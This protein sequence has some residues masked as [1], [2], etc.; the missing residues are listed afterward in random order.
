MLVKNIIFDLGGVLVDW[1]PKYVYRQVF[2]T[3]EA[4]NYFLENI[5]TF[6]W[7]EQQ[8]GGR[9]IAEAEKILYNKFPQYTAEIKNFYGRWTEM[10]GGPILPTLKVFKSL[11]ASNKY[12]VYALTN[13]SAETWPIAVERYDF[14]SWFKGVLVSGQENLKKPDPKI[15]HLICDRYNLIAEETLFIDDNA[16][17]IKTANELGFKTIHFTSVDKVEEL[18][19]YL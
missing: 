13:W 14:L 4:V 6:E 3:E 11:L 12:N 15:F 19:S 16:R 5:C 17:N 9:T 1:N 7:N 2:Q 8:D 18:K 10:L